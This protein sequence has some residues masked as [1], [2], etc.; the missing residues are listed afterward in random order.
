MMDRCLFARPPL[1]GPSYV[2]L[3]T[4]INNNTVTAAEQNLQFE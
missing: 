2:E 4:I 3:A 1:D